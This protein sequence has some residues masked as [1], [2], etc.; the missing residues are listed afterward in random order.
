MTTSSDPIH[1]GAF[2]RAVAREI[3]SQASI[4]REISRLTPMEPL[5]CANCGHSE[6]DHV[7]EDDNSYCVGGPI[8]FGAY[9]GRE[10]P[11]ACRCKHF[12][13]AVVTECK[14]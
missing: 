10:D 2:A 9:N 14:E 12:R 4:A 5:F 6:D 7:V 3:L 13:P 1:D 11:C 8:S